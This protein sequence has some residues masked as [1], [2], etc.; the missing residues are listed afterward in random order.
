MKNLNRFHLNGLRAVEAVSRLGTLQRAAEELGVSPGAVSQHVIRAE[1]QLG[2]D[3]FIRTPRGLVATPAA[4]PL[5]SRL[6]EAFGRVE[7][8]LEAATKADRNVLTISVAPVFAS[9]WLVARL[10]RFRQAHPDIRVRIDATT[11]LVDLDAVDVDVAIR[12]GRGEW[13]DVRLERLLEQTVFPV[14]SPRL[15]RSITSPADL[16]NVPVV[17]DLNSTISW[18]T[19]LAP[20]GMSATDLRPG[21]GFTDAALCL[22]AA[23]AGQGVMLGWQTLAQD[24]IAAGLLVAPLPGR[25]T[26][27]NAYWLVTP[28][29]RTPNVAVAAFRRWLRQEIAVAREAFG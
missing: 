23:I 8:A 29:H 2:R 5:L 22:D 9:K 26:T 12:V 19:W 7:Q 10:S 11:E 24:A 17:L 20:H 18:D 14:C 25:A 13:K 4:E 3:I 21:D 28:R 15:A 16:A 6:G 1:R 27:G